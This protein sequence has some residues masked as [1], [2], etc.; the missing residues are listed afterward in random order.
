MR[1]TDIQRDSKPASHQLYVDADQKAALEARNGL[2][3]FD[4]VV[5]LIEEAKQ[6]FTLRPSIIQRL[7]R[8]AIKDIY[9]CAGNFRTGPVFINGT[10]H[11]PPEP[12]TVAE[13]VEKMCD[14]VNTRI[15]WEGID[16]PAL[17]SADDTAEEGDR[18]PLRQAPVSDGSARTG[19]NCHRRYFRRP[20]TA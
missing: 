3:Q 1:R 20:T 10:T 14:Y 8:L 6:G 17:S 4:E 12:D 11:Q 13:H 18:Q 16:E 2:I 19:R 7:Q 15:S 9:T 5:R